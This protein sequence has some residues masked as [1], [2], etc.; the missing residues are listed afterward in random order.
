MEADAQDKWLQGVSVLKAFLD[1][2]LYLARLLKQHR[3]SE[4]LAVAKVAEK[5][6]DPGLA[7]TDPLCRR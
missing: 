2:P 7:Q 1:D 4:L 6:A 3:W 5:D